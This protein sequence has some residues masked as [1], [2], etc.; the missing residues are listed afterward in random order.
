MTDFVW[1][2]FNPANQVTSEIEDVR[3]W[4]SDDLNL[5]VENGGTIRHHHFTLR[6]TGDNW[7]ICGHFRRRVQIGV[8]ALEAGEATIPS[9]SF[10]SDFRTP[11]EDA[12]IPLIIYVPG[13]GNVSCVGQ[14]TEYTGEFRGHNW[15]F[16][17]DLIVQSILLY[18]TVE[19]L[20]RVQ[21]PVRPPRPRSPPTQERRVRRRPLAEPEL[22]FLREIEQWEE[23]VRPVPPPAP[24][25]VPQPIP[26]PSPPSQVV[27]DPEPVVSPASE[28]DAQ[29]AITARPA[30]AEARNPE[31]LEREEEIPSAGEVD[32]LYEQWVQ[33]QW[34]QGQAARHSDSEEEGYNS[35]RLSPA[36]SP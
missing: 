12:Y 36:G 27:P 15:N 32:Q 20:Q 16:T 9:Q 5:P 1:H 10:T 25:P 29:T 24:Q 26:P 8:T 17:F 34:E 2:L 35:P 6:I 11:R 31:Q 18:P 13:R 23:R 30:E 21:R 28:G 22:A 19:I 14:I 3:E 7:Q 33:R 4:F